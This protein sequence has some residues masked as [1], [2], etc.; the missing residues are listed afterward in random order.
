MAAAAAE[1]VALDASATLERDM[2]CGV[3]GEAITDA[4]IL[5]TC[6]HHFCWSVNSKA[7]ALESIQLIRMV[8]RGGWGVGVGWVRELC[9]AHEVCLL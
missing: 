2:A 3:C 1:A 9:M 5:S 7:R 6:G 8:R 4:V